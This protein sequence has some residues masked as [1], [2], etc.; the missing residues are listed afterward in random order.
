MTVT[1][2]PPDPYKHPVATR[3]E[4]VPNQAGGT[5]ATP[6]FGQE[7][8]IG[9]EGLLNVNTA[10]AAALAAVP[11]VPENQDLLTYDDT[12]GGMAPGANG[13]LDAE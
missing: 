5:P 4:A 1:A 11:F 12:T 9:V 3:P 8:G 10:P 7:D 2:G 13:V 6:N